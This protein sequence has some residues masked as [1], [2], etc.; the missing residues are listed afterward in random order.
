LAAVPDRD[1][2]PTGA[3]TAAI[4]WM[5]TRAKWRETSKL[6][7]SRD[8]LSDEELLALLRR[9]V[10]ELGILESEPPMKLVEGKK[11]R[12][13]ARLQALN[14]LGTMLFSRSLTGGKQTFSGPK[15]TSQ[16]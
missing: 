7:V 5:K 14:R 1:E 13:G 8:R 3:V 4:F 6:E 10:Q 11:Q 16:K 2:R 9:E 15:A 12:S